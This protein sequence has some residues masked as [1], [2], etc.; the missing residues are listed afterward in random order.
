MSPPLK[1]TRAISSK[2]GRS[3]T[4]SLEQ[5]FMPRVGPYP[6]VISFC[7]HPY[8]NYCKNN[9]RRYPHPECF[10]PRACRTLRRSDIRRTCPG[11]WSELPPAGRAPAG[12]AGHGQM[13]AA[14]I[15]SSHT[16]NSELQ[17]FGRTPQGLRISRRCGD[18]TSSKFI[19]N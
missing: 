16:S 12:L 2:L 19:G 17:L 14:A 5:L 18:F 13:G 10:G 8:I 3:S 9:L 6:T 11:G 4:W 1:R 15:M 7:A